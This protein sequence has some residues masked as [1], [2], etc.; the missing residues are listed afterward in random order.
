MLEVFCVMLRPILEYCCSVYHP[1]LTCEMSEKIEGMQKLALRIIFGF[2]KS[3]TEILIENNMTTMEERRKKM[4]CNYANKLVK[5]ERFTKWFPE[6]NCSVN[7][8][9]KKKYKEVHA[10]TN[11][12]YNSPVFAMRRLLNEQETMN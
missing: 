4:F 5:S 8:R 6:N 1:L 11:R 2:D 9:G 7:L 3:Y 12:L 10:N